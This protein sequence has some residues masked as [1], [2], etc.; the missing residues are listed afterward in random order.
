M[1]ADMVDF[2]IRP[3]CEVGLFAVAKPDGSQRF[4]VDAR[5]AN[6]IFV[7]PPAMSLP[8]PDLLSKL[9]LPADTPV[10]SAKADL[11]NCFHRVKTPVWLRSYFCLPPVR[12]GDVGMAHQYGQDTLIYP[13]CTTLPM[14]W[15]HSAALVQASNEHSI[16]G[17]PSFSLADQITHD[18]DLYIDRPRFFVY[19]DDFVLIGTDP[20]RLRYLLNEYVSCMNN[21]GKL[22]KPSKVVH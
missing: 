17:M 2:T 21:L 19:I 18:G 4:I 15:S 9:Q 14:G 8:T 7:D 3:L 10:Y 16:A 6:E 11:D 22:V 12:A 20:A 13:Q 5:P 1:T